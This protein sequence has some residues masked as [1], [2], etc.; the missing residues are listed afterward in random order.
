VP[1]DDGQRIVI[2]AFQSCEFGFGMDINPELLM[3][4][5]V[6]REGK[7]YNDTK[8]AISKRGT[9]MKKQITSSPFIVEFAY[10]VNLEGYWLYDHMVLQMDDCINIVKLLRPQYDV[11]FLFDYSCGHDRQCEDG[12]NNENVSK[13]NKAFYVPH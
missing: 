1:K 5:N 4:V 2:R 10:G 6:T 13:K 12:L 9:D 8:A 3:E 7:K 11:L